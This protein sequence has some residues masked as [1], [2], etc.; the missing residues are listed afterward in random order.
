MPKLMLAPQYSYYIAWSPGD[1]E[2]AASFLELP[3]LSG[4][5]V[6]IPEAIEELHEA[7]TC[8]LEVAKEKG[9]EL[10]PPIQK[11]APVPLVIIDR[12]HLGQEH[13]ITDT[14]SILPEGLRAKEPN[15]PAATALGSKEVLVCQF[16]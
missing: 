3:G 11:D 13:L 12:S 6:T 9:F 15:R 10:P 7:L 1:K 14:S 4:M 5:G 2:F 8:W 16:A